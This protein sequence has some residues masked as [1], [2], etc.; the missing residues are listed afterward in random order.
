MPYG[1]IVKGGPSADAQMEP[2]VAALKKQ[3]KSEAE[4]IAICKASL[5]KALSRGA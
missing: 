4:A 1:P 3:G 5:A 2:C